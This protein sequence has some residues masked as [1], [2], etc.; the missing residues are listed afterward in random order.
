M[1]SIFSFGRWWMLV[2]L[3]WVENRRRYGLALLAI[4]G[5]LLFWLSFMMEMNTHEPLSKGLQFGTYYVGLF[6]AGCLF[7]SQIFGALN[8]KRAAIQYLMVPASHLEK[9]LCGLF[10]AVLLFFICYTLVF[11]MVDLPLVHLAENMAK[12]I[13]AMYKGG[14][15]D[16]RPGVFVVFSPEGTHSIDDPGFFLLLLFFAIQGAFILGS[17]YFTRY[18]PLKTIVSGLFLCI[19]GSLFMIK[20]IEA[21]LPAGWHMDNFFDWSHSD[22]RQQ[23][24]VRL[25]LETKKI[26]YWII[27]Y[28]L[29]FIFWFITW[30]RLK[31]K[32]V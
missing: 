25:P 14:F 32:E 16:E 11:Y 30:F 24:W 10:F 18:A 23:E 19:L 9:L 4:G 6:F 15:L 8:R 2:G 7:G 3:H 27:E 13:P 22:G 29:P 28:S 1:N 12:K 31:E 5:L 26:L 21:N 20:G 17:I